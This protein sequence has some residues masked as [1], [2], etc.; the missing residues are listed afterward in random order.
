MTRMLPGAPRPW[1][2]SHLAKYSGM[3]SHRTLSACLHS[4]Q[5]LSAEP[6][7]M[8]FCESVRD[9]SANRMSYL[10]LISQLPMSPKDKTKPELVVSE[11]GQ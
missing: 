9:M 11:P 6:W 8:A 4:S 1:T 3:R 2:N 7:S 10:E 5:N